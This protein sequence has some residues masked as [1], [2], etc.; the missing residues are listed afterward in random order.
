MFPLADPAMAEIKLGQLMSFSAGIRGNNPGYVNGEP[1]TLDPPGPDGYQAMV[2][3]IAWGKRD[4]EARGART[5]T[6]TLWCEPGGGYSYST[7]SIHLASI[8]LRHV[9]GMELERFVRERLAEPMGWGRFGYGYKNRADV[10]HTPGGGGI[11]VRAT[12]MLRFGYLLL[13]EGRWG[14][15]RLIPAD[16]VRM[17]GRRSPYNPHYP[18]SLQFTV[19]ADGDVAEAPRDAFWKRGSGGHAIYV[20]P[21][22]ELVIWKLGGRDSQY[23]REDTGMDPSPAAVAN[24]SIREGWEQTVA[25]DVAADKTLAMV[26]AA[27]TDK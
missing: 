17:C 12:D 14:D 5:T 26:V 23:S 24:T 1:V 19:N 4:G 18:Y 22:L 21:S 9:T 20:V 11:A 8:M 7:A 27:I 16:Y 25:D 13:N 15:R 3:E 6:S 2:D 10:T